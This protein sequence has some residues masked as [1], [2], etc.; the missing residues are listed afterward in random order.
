MK[1]EKIGNFI[2]ELRIKNNMTQKELA[3]KLGVT[4]QA[5]SKW[6]N[7]KNIPDI[8]VMTQ[9]ASLFKVDITDVLNGEVNK[10]INIIPLLVIAFLI[11]IVGVVIYSLV[12]NNYEFKTLS[13]GCSEFK[14]TGSAAY[15]KDT[16]SIYIS[17][18][19][20]CDTDNTIYDD[21]SC[22]LYET[23]DNK[24]IKISDCTSSSNINLTDYL[25]DVT[26]NVEKYNNVCKN[27]SE[28]DIYLEISATKDNKTTTYKAPLELNNNCN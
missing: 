9:I 1:Q 21:I 11:V 10:K 5:V 6:E 7:G 19:D 24:N 28:A 18:I 23:V 8:A 2:K 4:Y 12:D 15:N 20:Y 3:D 25:K 27:F 14:I 26:I 16:S 22:S 17:N 13:S